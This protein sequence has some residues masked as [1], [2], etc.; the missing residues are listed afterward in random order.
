MVCS[1]RINTP[2][3][4]SKALSYLVASALGITS[5]TCLAISE[6]SEKHFDF[7]YNKARQAFLSVGSKLETFM[8]YT[9]PM[10]TQMDY[11]EHDPRDYDIYIKH[12]TANDLPYLMYQFEVHGKEVW[13]WIWIHP[14]ESGPHHV[15]VG[16]NVDTLHQIRQLRS[17]SSA[18]NIL[19][20]AS[21]ESLL[22]AAKAFGNHNIYD[23]TFCGI[24]SDAKLELLNVEEKL[25][26]L[27][28]E[29]VIA[30]SSL[31]II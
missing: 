6:T 24:V 19:L 18:F 11:L 13:P 23:E 27:S 10:T 25:L 2:H 9:A 7:C 3:E 26:M 28:D 22:E 15:F 12:P 21:K 31:T 29:R 20:I 14:N 8:D 1:T 16:V 30:Y 4:G 5:V 17:E